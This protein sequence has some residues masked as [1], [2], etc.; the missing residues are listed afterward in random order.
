MIVKKFLYFQPFFENTKVVLRCL[1]DA[2]RPNAGKIFVFK[3][4]N[5]ATNYKAF[6]PDD[7]L[8]FLGSETSN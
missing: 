7:A 3:R 2:L 1:L 5:L 4:R 6:F 8:R